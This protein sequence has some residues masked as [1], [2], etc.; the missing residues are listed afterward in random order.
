LIKKEIEFPAEILNQLKTLTGFD[1]KTFLDSQKSEAV[2]SV[3]INPS[4]WMG[5]EHSGEVIPWCNDGLY[6]SHRPE[7]IKDPFYHA[8]HY[9]VQEA[10]SMFVG[11]LVDF[12]LPKKEN[13]TVLDLCAAPGG[14]STHIL[15]LLNDSSIL[16]S[17]EISYKRVPILEENITRWGRSNVIVTNNSPSDFSTLTNFFD[18]IL[19][20]APCSGSGLFRK[21]PEHLENWDCSYVRES[22]KRQKEILSE[23][24]SSLKPNGILI[25]STCSFSKEENEEIVQW[26]IKE[27]NF[28]EENFNQKITA[29]IIKTGPGSFRFFPG[30]INGEG[31]FVSVL[32]KPT[33]SN[34][35]EIN[36]KPRKVNDFIRRLSQ[37][38][39]STLKKWTL[40]NDLLGHYKSSEFFIF[41]EERWEDLSWLENKLKIRKKGVKVGELKGND[42]SPAHDLSLSN[43]LNDE[44]PQV[45]FSERNFFS[46]LNRN[47][48]EPVNS[49]SKGF[50]VVTFKNARQG[51]AKNIGSRV[52]NYFPKE[53]RVIKN[54]NEFL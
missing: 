32:R 29:D 16:I 45:N 15:S 30:K 46:Y 13:L 25:Y 4:K 33:E 8:G 19:V 36:Y 9:Y 10:S 2:N 43:Y 49:T 51:W 1:E 18:L 50:F 5:N 41:P 52:N 28:S 3:R 38:E 44:I 42:F 39:K 21:M 14:K 6:L 54:L 17:N 37:N 11:S 27:K 31:F 23:I 34:S 47:T 40:S 20:D 24:A 7:Y 53:W 35:G 26:L 12:Y 48:L 22:A